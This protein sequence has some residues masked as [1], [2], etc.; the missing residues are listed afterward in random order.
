MTE[1][2][3]STVVGK[4][5]NWITEEA[6][7][8]EGVGDKVEQLR[9]ELRWMQSF[10]K[11]ADAECYR[12]YIAKAASRSSWNIPAK[13]INL[14]EVGLGKKIGKIQSR[15]RNISS[16]QDHFGITTGREGSEGTIASANE[17]LRWW[18]QTS[19]SIEKDDLVD[20]I[21]DTKA[22][23]R[24]LSR[25]EPRRRVVSIV[26]MGCL[27]KTTLA[28]K[29]YN[30]S[31]I[32]YQFDCQAFV[33]MS[34]DYSRETLER[35]IVAT[36]P[37]CNMDD[38]KKLEEEALVLK[39]HQLLK[40]ERDEVSSCSLGNRGRK[41]DDG[42]MQWSATRSGG[43]WRIIVHEKEDSRGMETHA[44]KHHLASH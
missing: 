15:I 12:N 1:F 18:R 22:L 40:L 41:R 16:Q 9:D 11:D 35:I 5:T 8:L 43:A 17:R 39:L 3:V 19:P 36:S 33:Y 2:V 14:Y 4:L 26:G 6:L 23:L 28:K 31:D 34:K 24:Q 7:L 20:L 30:N 44:S 21:E 32:K 25:M 13:L 10:L 38:L 27:S 37:D 42:E 29:L